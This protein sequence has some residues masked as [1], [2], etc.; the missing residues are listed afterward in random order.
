MRKET[1]KDS[2]ELINIAVRAAKSF[3]IG[4]A[5]LTLTAIILLIIILVVCV[6]DNI[7]TVIHNY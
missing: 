2:E 6:A 3:L 4:V 7:Y 1:R 5:S